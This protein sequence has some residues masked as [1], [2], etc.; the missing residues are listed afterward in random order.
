MERL[1]VRGRRLLL[2]LGRSARVSRLL[3]P[4]HAATSTD[5]ITSSSCDGVRAIAAVRFC[6]KPIATARGNGAAFP[7]ASGSDVFAYPAT[8]RGNA[9][10]A[11]PSSRSALR[12]TTVCAA[13]VA[14][15]RRLRFD[16]EQGRGDD[17]G[18]YHH[19]I[20]FNGGCGLGGLGGR[21]YR[22]HVSG[23]VRCDEHCRQRGRQR[24]R[25][26]WRERRRRG[27]QRERQRVCSDPGS[28]EV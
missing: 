11:A 16:G 12:A 18:R 10:S 15:G 20:R 1:H 3:P 26:R 27:R 28:A 22:C 24:G 17:H 19:C 5:A 14:A 7:A 2:Q 25:Q 9:A 4:I 23:D 21:N 8:A 6:A 13:A